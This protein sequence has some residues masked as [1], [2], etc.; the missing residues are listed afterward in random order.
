MMRLLLMLLLLLLLLVV[1]ENVLM[2]MMLR[3][4][5]G[6]GLRHHLG[7]AHLAP[8]EAVR[9]RAR[10]RHHPRHATHQVVKFLLKKA[11]N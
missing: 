4:R 6:Q 9:R 8:R 7:L 11:I 1:V 10:V 2:V 5:V 3:C